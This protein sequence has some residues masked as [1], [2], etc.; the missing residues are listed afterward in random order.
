M[1]IRGPAEKRV[2]LREALIE[3]ATKPWSVDL[4][5]SAEVVCNAVTSEDVVLFRT[6]ASKAYPAAGLT[7]WEKDD[8]YYVPNIVPLKPG[9]L[10]YAQY[11]A[12]L[13]DFIKCIARPTAE[14]LGFEITATKAEQTLDDWISKDEA[15]KLRR[16]SHAANKSTGANHPSDERRWFDFIVAVHR[17]GDRLYAEQL[18][19]WLCEADGWSEDTAHKLAGDYE[20]S[21][22]LLKYYEEH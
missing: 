2:N 3:A 21:L 8:G 22:A 9:E 4:E 11:N 19:R 18:A 5:S 6:E 7:L 1:D 14:K 20:K 17:S 16:F 10:T 13:E 12:V 15:Q